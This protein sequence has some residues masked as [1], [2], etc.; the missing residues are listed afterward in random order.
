MRPKPWVNTVPDS[1]QELVVKPF[2]GAGHVLGCEVLQNEL[3][4]LLAE[5]PP[6]LGVR[7]QAPNRI[8]ERRRILGRHE[9]TGLTV[10]NGLGDAAHVS[11][12]HGRPGQECLEQREWESFEARGQCENV[13]RPEIGARI[14]APALPDHAV[15]DPDLSGELFEP[16]PFASFADENECGAVDLR[17]RANQQVEALLSLQAP[18]RADDLARPRLVACDTLPVGDTVVDREHRIGRKADEGLYL[19]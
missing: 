14:L 13:E 11:C 17:E 4:P 15:G 6:K 1:A 16:T 18:N 8:R 9:K 19:A 5:P 2:E 7:E 3:T 10:A 12:D